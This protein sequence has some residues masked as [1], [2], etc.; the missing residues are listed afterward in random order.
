MNEQDEIE[1]VAKDAEYAAKIKALQDAANAL[2]DAIL[3]NAP[4]CAN[5]DHAIHLIRDGLTCA[6]WAIAQTK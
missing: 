3:A 1:A 5:R 4:E 6:Y 2:G